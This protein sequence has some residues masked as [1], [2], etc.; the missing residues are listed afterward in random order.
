MRMMVHSSVLEKEV[1]CKSV[2]ADL[3]GMMIGTVIRDDAVD[4]RSTSHLH[5]DSAE[6]VVVLCL[7]LI[8]VVILV[9]MPHQTLVG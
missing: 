5:F 1:C 6:E 2:D 8:V 7:Q 4:R 9:S 3:Q